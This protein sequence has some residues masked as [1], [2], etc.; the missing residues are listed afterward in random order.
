[1]AFVGTKP[2]TLQDRAC[3]DGVMAW[4]WEMCKISNITFPF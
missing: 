4:T 3:C 2:Q 1:M